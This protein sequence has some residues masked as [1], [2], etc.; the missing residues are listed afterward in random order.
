[1]DQFARCSCTAS[2]H[3]H[4]LDVPCSRVY[5][6]VSP[7]WRC[8]ATTHAHRDG[9]LTLL[10]L[11]GSE[12]PARDRCEWCRCPAIVAPP[13]PPPTVILASGKGDSTGSPE[14]DALREEYVVQERADGIA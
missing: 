9:A 8:T 11:Y 12:L 14:Q 6:I 5:L 7:I 10:S 2:G 4:P 13:P 1:M 3:H